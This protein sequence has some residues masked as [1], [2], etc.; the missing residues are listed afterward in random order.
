[1]ENNKAK[2]GTILSLKKK[3]KIFGIRL[4]F[5]RHRL[6]EPKELNGNVDIVGYCEVTGIDLR[7]D[8][9][10]FRLNISHPQLPF[11]VSTTLYKKDYE[12]EHC[13]LSVSTLKTGYDGF[14]TLKPIS[15]KKD[16]IR[17]LNQD[18]KN[19]KKIFNKKI[20]TLEDKLKLFI[21]SEDKINKH[22]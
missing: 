11:G 21:L 7:G 13:Y 14:Y 9:N 16:L 12:N 2:D 5:G 1:M 3:D 4:S 22:I 10:Y 17:L 8:S 20:N 18:I 19:Q 6:S 15:W